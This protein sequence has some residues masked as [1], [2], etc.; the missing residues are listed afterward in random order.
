TRYDNAWAQPRGFVDCVHGIL[1]KWATGATQVSVQ[2][3]EASGPVDDATHARMRLIE[4]HLRRA[5]IVGNVIDLRRA[6]AATLVKLVDGISAAMFLVS[7]GGRI[8]HANA[9]GHAMLAQGSLL[10]AA[11]GRLAPI[12][13]EAE[14]ALCE[15]MADGGDAAVGVQGIA[16]PL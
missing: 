11:G 5:M 1:D 3:H 8:V 10:R 14:L 13:A 12:D 6:E 4:P 15:A 9:S 2:R 16:V 7:A